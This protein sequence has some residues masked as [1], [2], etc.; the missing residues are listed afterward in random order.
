[1]RLIFRNSKHNILYLIYIPFHRY[2][3]KQLTRFLIHYLIAPTLRLKSMGW[4][5]FHQKISR[6]MN[7]RSKGSKCKVVKERINQM[8][9]CY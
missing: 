1:M 9:G 5:E 4:R 8:R 6:S 2:T 3:K 7:A